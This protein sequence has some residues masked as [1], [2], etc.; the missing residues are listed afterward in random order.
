MLA[1]RSVQLSFASL[2]LLALALGCSKTEDSPTG[3]GDSAAREDGGS[4]DE[5]PPLFN[6]DPSPPAP[7]QLVPALDGPSV[8]MQP[9]YL[10]GAFLFASA[11]AGTLQ[12]FGQSI[13]LAPSEARDLA[14]FGQVLGADPRVDDVLAYL[15]VDPNARTS[16]S[17]RPLI[18]HAAAAKQTID[19]AGPL[20]DELRRPD[21][22]VP[23]ATAQPPLSA[24]AELFLDRIESLGA[25][26]R[27]YLPIADV[28]GN[29]RLAEAMKSL[30]PDKWATTCT[31][32]QPTLICSGSSDSVFVVRQLPGAIQLDVLVFFKSAHDEPDTELRRAI[33]QQA[34][35]MPA[36]QSI[37][38]VGALRGDANLL[39][40]S[41]PA[42]NLMRTAEMTGVIS[43]MQW[44]GQESLADYQLRDDA[45]R[46][47]HE[48]ERLFEG[49]KI[50][51]RVSPQRIHA[52]FAW[53]PTPLGKQKMGEV[54]ELLQVDADVP[55]LAALC[56]GSLLCARSR[57][58]PSS[59]RFASLATGIFADLQVFETTFDRVDE[60]QIM[61]ML[62]LESWPNLVGML[63]KFPGQT[64]EPPESVIAENAKKA[65]ERVLA[66][67]FAVRK[68]DVVQGQTNAEWVGFAR[69]PEMD[70]ATLR[71]L[72]RMGELGLAPVALDGVPGS[73]ESAPLPDDDVPGR[74]YSI[75][76]PPVATGSW[77]WA[78]V[79]DGDERVRWLAGLPRDDGAAPLAYL[80]IRDLWRLIGG[81]DEVA[82]EFGYAQAWLSG[83]SL[84]AQWTA[85][86]EGP[87]LRALFEKQQP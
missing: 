73:I 58:L 84:R 72:M 33:A 81:V 39:V 38:G 55:A 45:L 53:L 20:F 76:D 13:P 83:R 46:A 42:V 82:R 3:E 66:F 5:R 31:S 51:A 57:G 9:G 60:E 10:D 77:G 23:D 71:G 1:R 70:L 74:F 62:M 11:R 25:H 54:F 6:P 41:T 36:A 4:P 19:A 17:I 50:E 22:N 49:I 21:P 64:M 80:E 29:Q 27:W 59:A 24:D 63:A 28:S 44:G 43:Q 79:A 7:A 87:E 15:G 67:G 52:N 8:G 75:S 56:D 61:L 48:P 86:P 2:L 14:E 69:M 37:P 12:E 85:G 47:F 34:V 35:A 16:L 65:A 68:L 40:A 30:R 32:L 18:E 26:L 78:M